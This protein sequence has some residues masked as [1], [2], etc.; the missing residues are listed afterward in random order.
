MLVGKKKYI[1]N[2][3]FALGSTNASWEYLGCAMLRK[4]ALTSKWNYVY[5]LCLTVTEGRIKA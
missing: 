1:V 5:I 3:P 2:V 4:M